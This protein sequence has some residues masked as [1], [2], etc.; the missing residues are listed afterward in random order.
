MEFKT[1]EE[2]IRFAISKEEASCQFYHDIAALMKD[3]TTR[4]IFEVLGRNELQHKENLEFELIKMGC[5]VQDDTYLV[6]EDDSSYI[7]VDERAQE[8]TYTE[9]LKLAIRKEKAAF[10]LFAELMVQT[11][12]PKLRKVFLELAE[13]EMR[14]V[15]HFENEYDNM[16]PQKK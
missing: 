4:L 1:L 10:Q 2:V 9:A 5:V 16:M 11:R 7:E 12:D 14:H 15:L 13:E 6:T 3:S 8:M